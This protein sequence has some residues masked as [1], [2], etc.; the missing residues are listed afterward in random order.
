MIKMRA[1][2]FV[3]CCGVIRAQS[4]AQISGTVKDPAGAAVA[5]AQVTATQTDTGVKRSVT[6]DAS[7][8]Y[9]LPDLPIGGYQLEVKAAGFRT[10]VQTGI[11]LQVADKVAINPVLNLG[12]VTDQ[13]QVAANAAQVETSETAVTETMDSTRVV[14]LPLDGRQVT[15]LVLLSGAATVS[16]TTSFVRD[17]PTVNISVAGGMHN[18]LTYLL[19]GASHNDP[20]NGLDLPLSFPDALQEFKLETSSLSAQYG[21]HSAGAVN[22]VTKSGT[23]EFHG[24][25][26]EFF[27][28]ATSMRVTSLLWCQTS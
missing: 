21:Q 24:D 27:R 2:L 26:F 15:D 9:V 17:Y 25:A 6:T 14:E 23:N 20:I 4:T 3:L 5:G 10:Y 8:L 18:G 12:Q 28:N 19:D 11:L 1:C 13:I 7:G 22:S 16:A